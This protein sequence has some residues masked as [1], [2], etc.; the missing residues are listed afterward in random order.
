MN[1]VCDSA[2][3]SFICNSLNTIGNELDGRVVVWIE[4]F[5]WYTFEDS[6]II[7][8]YLEFINISGDSIVSCS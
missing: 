3:D 8:G 5:T 7:G 1:L 6:Y 2:I 4:C